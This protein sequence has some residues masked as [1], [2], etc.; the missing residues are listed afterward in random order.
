MWLVSLSYKA[1]RQ[2]DG[3]IISFGKFLGRYSSIVSARYLRALLTV[4][5]TYVVGQPRYGEGGEA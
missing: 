3:S 1:H 4:I 2:V 5:N